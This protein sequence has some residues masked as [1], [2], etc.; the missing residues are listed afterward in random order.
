MPGWRRRGRASTTAAVGT[1]ARSAAAARAIVVG[2]ASRELAVQ[3]AP[4]WL[5]HHV[6]IT[7]DTKPRAQRRN[8]KLVWSEVVKNRDAAIKERFDVKEFPRPVSLVEDSLT[9]GEA[10]R[11]QF[12]RGPCQRKVV[13]TGQAKHAR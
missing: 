5:E 6:D 2:S 13:G 9:K 7:L 12:C 10:T 1:T 4:D 11:T 3:V 8:V